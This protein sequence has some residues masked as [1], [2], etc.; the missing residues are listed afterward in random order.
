[1]KSGAGLKLVA[2]AAWL[3]ACAQTS[4]QVYRIEIDPIQFFKDASGRNRFRVT[5]HIRNLTAYEIHCRDG[6]LQYSFN[7][8]A[9]E[10]RTE[11]GDRL[12]SGTIAAYGRHQIGPSENFYD[13]GG[14]RVAASI[15]NSLSCE[16]TGLRLH[17]MQ[18]EMAE[19]RQRKNEAEA[20]A[21]A[22]EQARAV[23]GKQLREYCYLDGRPLRSLDPN[24][25]EAACRAEFGR[26]FEAVASRLSA[27]RR[28][29]QQ[30]AQDRQRREQ[31][32]QDLQRSYESRDERA[33]QEAE[34]NRLW[35]EERQR[36]QARNA[37]QARI[38][39]EDQIRSQ[40]RQ[41]A[42]ETTERARAADELRRREAAAAEQQRMQRQ[43]EEQALEA[44][45]REIAA[46][47]AR[48]AEIEASK[49]RAQAESSARAAAT[50]ERET[51]RSV[52]A[53]AA[54]RSKEADELERLNRELKE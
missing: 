7:S 29:Q 36:E 48:E 16:Q 46:R 13:Y 10:P 39:L 28:E 32:G 9:G 20:Q 19:E 14:G 22:A 33:R 44:A 8:P 38:Q 51:R 24:I 49:R 35:Y 43:R 34:R 40:E 52:D 30:Q 37:E 2:A 31:V 17:Q 25:D 6:E 42:L 45:R 18:Q 1:M 12:I 11:R 27:I 4:A 21:R 3:L 5:A 23:R 54:R 53:N 47:R 15:G 50:Q 26:E 41:R